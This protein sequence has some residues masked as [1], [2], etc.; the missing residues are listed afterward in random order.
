MLFFIK[1]VSFN[2]IK[3]FN[4][5]GKNK[6]LENSINKARTKKIYTLF[7]KNKR[8]RLS[9][10]NLKYLS[11]EKNLDT[12]D[13]S[14]NIKNYNNNNNNSNAKN[15]TTKKTSNENNILHANSYT[16]N[17]LNFNSTNNKWNYNYNFNINSSKPKYNLA[18]S[19]AINF[20]KG[21]N[22]NKF[23][24]NNFIKKSF[25]SKKSAKIRNNNFMGNNFIKNDRGSSVEQKYALNS[26]LFEQFINQYEK[27]IK[28]ALL[29]IGI[30]PNEK[31]D[32]TNRDYYVNEYDNNFNNYDNYKN[33]PFL[34][35]NNEQKISSIK[36]KK[37]K[38]YGYN[39]NSDNAL[40]YE[41]KI[42]MNTN[43]NNNLMSSTNSNNG[44]NNIIFQNSLKN[45]ITSNIDNYSFNT[46]LNT[47]SHTINSIKSI[48]EKEN[49]K[50]VSVE[51][52]NNNNNKLIMIEKINTE[53]KTRAVSTNPY[54]I[55][56]AIEI[57][58]NTNK[59]NIEL[60]NYHYYNS[61][62]IS[63]YY[64]SKYSEN[65]LS[66]YEIG[67]T[68]GKGAYAIV[69]V[70][71]NK[72]TKER[73]AVKIY[74]KSKLNDGSKKKCVYR[75]IEILKKINHK[76]IA[77]LYDVITTDKQIL[78]LQELVIGISLREYYNNEIRNQKGISE[79]KSIIFKKI[80]KQI[81]EAMNYIHK[82]NIAHRDIKL[83]NILMTKNYEIKI[84]DFG[85][86]MYNPENKLQNFFCGTPNY[87]P[88]EIAFKKPYNGEK[89]DLWSLGV[90]VYKIFCADFP[91]KGKNEKE[92]YKSIERG[93]FRMANYTPEYVKKIILGM[94]V[95]NPNKRMSCEA[96]LKS[97]WLSD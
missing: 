87:M 42:P 81:F 46:N 31:N 75:E 91:F 26:K 43:E 37:N 11:K 93:K 44:N 4:K 49:Q 62:N 34:S 23:K 92:L 38:F 69:K 73:Y 2:K 64:K 35:N 5:E 50:I 21:G 67:R 48:K 15:I 30:N 8:L 13:N 51:S 55:N 36:S 57:D 58:D 88:P 29:D 63:T 56:T 9:K 82:R 54:S 53:K 12:S 52:E 19:T 18:S 76:N 61:S 47:K 16:K 32:E 89:A 59:N 71:T 83:E 79:H 70:C 45:T 33:L 41:E 97:E 6:M 77:K 24:T 10:Q 74:E 66:S 90:L 3:L 14:Y 85:F 28:R 40:C 80:F 95:L 60:R 20:W 25:N 78:I 86:G 65:D 96:V 68:L 1:K 22:N 72:I 84:I 7:P 39:A 94:I 17:R 27:K